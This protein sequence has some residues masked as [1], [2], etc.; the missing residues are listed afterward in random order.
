M[1]RQ[2]ERAELADIPTAGDVD[3]GT[4][5]D[6]DAAGKIGR[7]GRVADPRVS[8]LVETRGAA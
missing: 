2:V 3:R 5:I 4:G 6:V 8:T 7:D 1:G